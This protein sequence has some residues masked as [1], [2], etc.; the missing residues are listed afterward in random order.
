MAWNGQVFSGYA[1]MQSGSKWVPLHDQQT[2][3]CYPSNFDGTL[4]HKSTSATFMSISPKKC[5]GSVTLQM[6][7]LQHR[8]CVNP[9][10]IISPLWVLNNRRSY[11]RAY[12][13]K[14]ERI[15]VAVFH[16]VFWGGAQC[17]GS[18]G[19]DNEVDTRRMSRGGAG[20]R[21]ASLWKLRCG[22]RLNGHGGVVSRRVSRQWPGM[23]HPFLI[24]I[25]LKLRAKRGTDWEDCIRC[26][27]IGQPL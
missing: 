2:S 15:D 26:H 3:C 22:V 18:L 12:G 1:T 9:F 13:L 5:T 23:F 17:S 21:F 4:H 16:C 7:S 19:R 25:C 27:E 14:S 8:N 20:L 11:L 6:W 10:P 24:S